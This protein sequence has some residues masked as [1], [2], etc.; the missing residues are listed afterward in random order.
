MHVGF[1]FFLALSL[2][3]CLELAGKVIKLWDI[4][5]SLVKLSLKQNRRL[6]PQVPAFA[7]ARTFMLI[8]IERGSN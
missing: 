7:H 4:P 3:L 5:V 6:R 2:L 1:R 8:L